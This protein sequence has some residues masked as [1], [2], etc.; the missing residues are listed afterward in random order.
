MTLGGPLVGSKG[1]VYLYHKTIL[2]KAK[3]KPVVGVVIAGPLAPP[4]GVEGRSQS[5]GGLAILQSS[6][7]YLPRFQRT[8]RDS[9]HCFVRIRGH[10]AIITHTYEKVNHRFEVSSLHP[11]RKHLSI[12]SSEQ[13]G[14]A[15]P[16]GYS[17]L[18][19]IQDLL[20]A[21]VVVCMVLPA[22][23]SRGTDRFR[24]GEAEPLEYLG[25]RTGYIG[26]YVS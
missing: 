9:L 18:P 17:E 22:C 6:N 8:V 11:A 24:V 2:H 7:G 15:E 21:A 19:T 20:M 14:R 4:E 5:L 25:W 16:S 23:S 13:G 1:Y 3:D 10:N 26:F 12:E